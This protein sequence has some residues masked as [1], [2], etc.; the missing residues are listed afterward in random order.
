MYFRVEKMYFYLFYVRICALWLS[1]RGC[2]VL[3][4][5]LLEQQKVIQLVILQINWIKMA[6]YK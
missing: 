3:L 4:G 6:R 2:I 5:S 1:C